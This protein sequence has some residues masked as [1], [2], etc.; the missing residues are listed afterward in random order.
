MKTIILLALLVV[1]NGAGYAMDFST[2][3]HDLYDALNWVNADNDLVRIYATGQITP[4]THEEMERFANEN[5]INS[6]IILFNS[7]GG[8]AC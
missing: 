6:S 7:L 3:K 4:K 8:F 5:G 2:P 1:L